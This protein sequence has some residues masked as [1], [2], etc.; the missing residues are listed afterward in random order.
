MTPA[1]SILIV[2]DSADL[3]RLYQEYL[4]EEGFAVH[5]ASSG[6]EALEL[7]ERLST[8]DLLVVDCLMPHMNGAAF[9]K[10][11][12]ARKPDFRNATRIIGMS[13]LIPDAEEVR[14]MKPLVN[15]M[16]EKTSNLSDLLTLISN[17]V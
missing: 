16:V 2:D 4:R 3:V 13:G 15:R 6:T 14:E 5:I 17:E 10:E 11:L 12:L 8:L 9:L 7:L 1:K